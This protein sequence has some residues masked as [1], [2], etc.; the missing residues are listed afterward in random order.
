MEEKFIEN[1]KDKKSKR[2]MFID[3][4]KGIAIICII[5]G[6]LGINNINRVVFTFHVPIF[7]MITGY[8]IN[9]KYTIKEFI[10]NKFKRL[11][12]PYF[13]TSFVIILLSLFSLKIYYGVNIL[14]KLGAKEWLI[15]AIYGAGDNHI[16]LGYNFKAIGAIWFLWASFWASILLRSS[17]EFKKE[18]RILFITV[19]FLIG[20]Y[21]SKIIWLPL[22]I[23]A[24]F[25]ATLFMYVGYLINIYFE[26]YKNIY[27]KYKKFI[28]IISFIIWL[29][30][31]YNFKS[32]WLVHCDIGRGVVDIIGCLC[33]CYCTMLLSKIINQKTKI[34]YKILDFSGKYSLLILCI[35]LVEL[36]F[37][38]WT[39]IIT[40]N[41]TLNISSQYSIILIAFG[42][43]I[44]DIGL[45]YILSKNKLINKVFYK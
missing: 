39:N 36:N 10:I 32:F 37:F 35:H 41:H 42:K 34:I 9:K 16:F 28:I 1:V 23:Q 3:I 20:Y 22:S 24:G 45:A 29:Q 31:I 14:N 11:I 40:I 21:T 44:F 17:L 6:H 26:K 8:F 19:L 7:F 2:V 18:Y 13:I 30:F 15:A 12:V 43:V 38:R 25:C 5:L 27:Y 33:A 4:A